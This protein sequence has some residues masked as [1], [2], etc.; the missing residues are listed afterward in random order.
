LKC[1]ECVKEECT[2]IRDPSSSNIG[3]MLQSHL[4]WA[5]SSWEE[6]KVKHTACVKAVQEYNVADTQCDVTQGDFE[7]GT[8]AH[9]Q[10]EWTAC[11]VNEM[12]CCARCSKEFDI[13]VNRVECAEKDRKIDWSAT[14]KIECYIDVLMASPTDEELAAKCNK[15]GKACINQWRENKY[16]ECSFVCSE[17]DFETGDYSVVRGVNTTHRS[18]YSDGDRC[19]VHLD[20][21][22]P[23]QG[24]CTKCPPPGPGPCGNA[25]ISTYYA[26][27]DL[28][29]TVPGLE[30]ENECHPD[31]HQKWWAYSR[32]EC[33]PCPSL[34][35]RTPMIVE[36]DCTGW[37]VVDTEESLIQQAGS[38]SPKPTS[39]LCPEGVE[40]V[41][42]TD[43]AYFV[44]RADLNIDGQRRWCESHNGDLASI[45]TS[46][47]NEAVM[48]LL[49]GKSAW[50]GALKTGTTWAWE[51]G[52]TWTSPDSERISND[53]LSNHQR[54]TRICIHSDRRWHDW[55]HGEQAKGG[56]CEIKAVSDEFKHDVDG[57]C[58]VAAFT[59]N[60]W[61]S[62]TF[63]GL[64][65]GCTYKMSAVIDTL[66][67]TDNE[68]M[69]FSVNGHVNNF[70]GRHGGSCNNGWSAHPHGFGVQLGS[71]GS[72]NHGWPDC[73]KRFSSHPFM[74]TP[75]GLA[76]VEMHIAVDQHIND[77]AWGWHSMKI[78]EI[79]CGIGDVVVQR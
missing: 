44:N 62:K 5:T 21:H 32:A 33:R 74:A 8:C 49:A 30:N 63:T 45:H 15:D 72:A 66:A 60:Q 39:A 27:Y 2:V 76:H 48:G 46:E 23:N 6:W 54:E 34:I 1:P 24:K 16:N 59:I 40:C 77:E 25:F 38:M 70:G 75:G 14:K 51:D 3:D 12:T 73:Y 18:A 58:Y 4:T 68:P 55:N 19:T 35:G 47:D 64:N 37:S 10:A 65:P 71:P 36:D 22:F 52:D 78:E 29:L 31:V 11:N 43:R 79:S 69:Q 41:G 61:P 53:G 26:E 50:I 67:S 7:T 28:T 42:G 9:R 56:V 13:E 20:I 57:T 17:V